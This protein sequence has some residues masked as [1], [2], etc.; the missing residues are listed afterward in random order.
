MENTKAL[1]QYLSTLEKNLSDLSPLD[2]SKIIIEI[3][4]HITENLEKFEDKKLE[5]ILNDLG[6]PQKVANHYR[7]DRGLKTFKADRHPILKWLSIT[8]VGSI[9]VFFIFVVV[10]VWKFTPIFKI[11]EKTQRVIILGGLVDING[12]SGKVKIADQYHFVDNKF[13]N[14]F[15]GAIDFPRDEYDELVVNFKSGILNFKPSIDNKL[16]WNCKME[17]AP[18]NDFLNRTKDI[19]EI[20]LEDFEG[21]SCDI[22]VPSNIK[23]TVDGKDAKVTITDADFHSYVEIANGQVYFNP[24]PELEY[25]YD[26]KVINGTASPAVNSKSPQAYE[27]RISVENG[28]IIKSN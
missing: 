17:T 5:D 14:Q 13:L 9:A 12:T 21:V 15:D 27:T 8:F 2:R 25:T 26:F 22:Q 4:E 3:N 7:L 24:N 28:Q 1:Q 16:S 20:D 23:L 19:I 10:I 18:T 11:D 6:S